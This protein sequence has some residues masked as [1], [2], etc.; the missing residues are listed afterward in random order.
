[1]LMYYHPQMPFPYFK[2]GHKSCLKVEAH[3]TVSYMIPIINCHML[4]LNALLF[5]GDT[6]PT[7]PSGPSGP[8]GDPG[9]GGDTGATGDTGPTGREGPTGNPGDDGDTGATGVNTLC[10]C[11]H[12]LWTLKLLGPIEHWFSLVYYCLEIMSEISIPA[13]FQFDSDFQTSRILH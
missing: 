5:A 9:P 10:L 7:G 3:C 1:M 11:W 2:R 13:T 6:G 4:Q 8:A 12:Q